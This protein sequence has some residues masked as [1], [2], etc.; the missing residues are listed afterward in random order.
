VLVK[1]KF[2]DY[3]TYSK[4]HEYYPLVS[5]EEYF[6]SHF[7][8]IVKSFFNGSVSKFASFFAED[9]NLNLTELEKMKKIIENKID[10]LKEK[11]G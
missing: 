1:K 2:I 7:K 3:N 4:V 8:G 5:K 11:N 6:R 9:E 10:K